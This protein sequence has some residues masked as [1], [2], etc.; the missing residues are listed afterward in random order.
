MSFN[1]EVQSGSSIRLPT[2]GKYCD[3]DI[4]VT[5]T[6]DDLAKQIIA[7]TV[8]NITDSSIETIGAYAFANCSALTEASFPN[9]TTVGMYAFNNATSLVTVDLPKVVTINSSTFANCSSLKNLNIPEVTK[10]TSNAIRDCSALEKIDLPK[11]DT[12]TT[13]VFLS[14]T[15]LTAVI[16]RL[17]AVAT[18]SNSNSFNSTPIANGTGYIY[19][20]DAL[21]DSY[22]TAT[23]WSV[24]A[25]QFRA[26]EDYPDICGG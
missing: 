8:E 22:K 17:N 14:C 24:Y 26:I 1:I 15:M 20:P 7:R 3:R 9:C 25:N 16:L 19:V 2:A 10:L 4:V 21:I 18:L 13:Q 6:S 11:A 5:A 12:I 23:N